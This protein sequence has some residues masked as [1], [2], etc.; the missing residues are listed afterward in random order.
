VFYTA[1]LYEL[2]VR[3]CA[4]LAA[5]APGDAR[6]GNEQAAIADAL[7]DRLDRLIA[8]LGGTTP[9]RVLA[10]RA[11]T[12]AERAR[13]GGS[14]DPERWAQARRG[15]D[16]CGDRYQVAYSRWHEAEAL[17][18]QDGDRGE[19]AMHIRDAHTVAGELEARPLLDELRSLARRA[20]IE[21]VDAA[22]L[23]E[24]SNATLPGSDLTQR[25]LE[26]LAL[27]ADGMT[28]REIAGEL[29]ISHKTASAHV[30]HVLAK[31][32]VANRVAAAAT[33]RHLGVG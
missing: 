24:E 5:G 32:G 3:A 15:W 29:F 9:P 30:S 21:L 28:N 22:G 12:A 31:L 10:A 27:L 20:R 18:A 14:G 6:V 19:A 11:G 33:A 26:V 7:L 1:R 16:A 23:T 8:Q 13:I 4:E 2:G 17:L 25:E